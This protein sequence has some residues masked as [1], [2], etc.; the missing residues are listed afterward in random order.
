MSRS[1]NW[2]PRTCRCFGA[3]VSK[4]S[5]FMGVDRGSGKCPGINALS[6][7]SMGRTVPHWGYQWEELCP[8]DG[9]TIIVGRL[10]THVL[11]PSLFST[12][13]LYSLPMFYGQ[14]SFLASLHPVLW[15]T[16]T[17]LLY[18]PL[19]KCPWSVYALLLL[20]VGGIVPQELKKGMQRATSDPLGRSL[21]TTALG[22]HL[23]NLG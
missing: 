15:S 20:T 9:V 18:T 6:L 4:L 22:D 21:G 1:L 7:V 3:G 17:F 14:L 10:W 13:A 23:E 12:Q 2:D 11:S 8:I 16:Y 5:G 19:D